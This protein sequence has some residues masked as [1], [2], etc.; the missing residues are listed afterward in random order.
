[1]RGLLA[2]YPL[3]HEASQVMIHRRLLGSGSALV[4]AEGHEVEVELIGCE[5]YLSGYA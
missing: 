2:A 1:M 3:S 4:P 5:E